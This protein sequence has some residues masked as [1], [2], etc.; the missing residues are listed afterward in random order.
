MP[1]VAMEVVVSRDTHSWSSVKR[2]MIS[3]VAGGGVS[4]GGL[5]G[6]GVGGGGR[7]HRSGGGW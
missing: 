1:I 3:V 4:G 5:K 2:L 7:A 6:G